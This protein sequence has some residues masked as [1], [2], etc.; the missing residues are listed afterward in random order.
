MPK[1]RQAVKEGKYNEFLISIKDEIATLTPETTY[2]L[3]NEVESYYHEHVLLV[4]ESSS[5]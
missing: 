4:D 5:K 1:L 3:L 2:V